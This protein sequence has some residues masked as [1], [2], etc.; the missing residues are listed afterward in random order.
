[1][2]DEIRAVLVNQGRLPVD[3]GR[4][5]DTDDLY[6]M[7]LTSHASVN[8]MLGLEDTFGME[9]PDDMLRRSTFASISAIRDALTQLGA[10][11]PIS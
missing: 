1:M 2:D 8:V 10:T 5:S 3:V 9:F 7:G 11:T 6:A 4:L